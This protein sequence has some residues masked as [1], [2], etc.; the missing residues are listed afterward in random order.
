MKQA[1]ERSGKHRLG[2]KGRALFHL[3]VGRLRGANNTPGSWKQGR[4]S[5]VHRQG[6][7]RGRCTFQEELDWT[8]ERCPRPPEA[9]DKRRT[10]GSSRRA[11]PR[12]G[13]TC[14]RHLLVYL[15]EKQFIKNDRMII[16]IH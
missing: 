14:G 12:G 11:A 9:F 16:L 13:L 2:G 7:E 4:G 3:Q 5:V 10:M 8:E 15:F 6:N 1:E